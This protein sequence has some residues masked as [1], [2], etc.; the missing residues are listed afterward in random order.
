MSNN[1]EQKTPTL[2]I[3]A[4]I[5]SFLIPIVGL[6]LGIISLIDIKKNQNLKGRGLAI[7]SI[8]ISVI[9]MI[10]ILALLIGSLYYFGVFNNPPF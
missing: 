6:I 5:F 10:I 9:Y 2:A 4:L 7:A 1:S 3:L 8:I